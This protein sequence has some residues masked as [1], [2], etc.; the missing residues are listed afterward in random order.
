MD[1]EFPD[2]HRDS[3]RVV[4]DT[5]LIAEKLKRLIKFCRDSYTALQDSPLDIKLQHELEEAGRELVK[6]YLEHPTRI[7]F[8]VWDI[9]DP[10]Y[11]DVDEVFT[12]GLLEGPEMDY[13]GAKNS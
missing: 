13:I 5:E 6:Y 12:L 2:A 9:Y 8:A 10:G 4:Y 11:I 1:T 7:F 3:N